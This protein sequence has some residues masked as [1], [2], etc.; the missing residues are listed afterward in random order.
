ML[1]AAKRAKKRTFDDDNVRYIK[2]YPLHFSDD[3]RLLEFRGADII[4]GMRLIN[5]VIDTADVM[6]EEFC[7]ALCFMEPSCVSYNFMMKG[8][9]G[10]H[11]CELNNATHKEHKEDLEEN[12]NYLHRGAKVRVS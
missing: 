8:G 2:L 12:S 6:S 5:H 7:G 9:T 11:K 3:C 4:E 1:E 10:K